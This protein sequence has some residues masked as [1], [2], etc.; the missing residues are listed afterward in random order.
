M[1]FLPDA[2]AAPVCGG[3]ELWGDCSGACR[4]PRAI[5]VCAAPAS[6]PAEFLAPF[7]MFFKAGSYLGNAVGCAIGVTLLL[8]SGVVPGL[9]QGITATSLAKIS[10]PVK[11]VQLAAAG[12][13]RQ[14]W[15]LR[16]GAV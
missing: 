3:W 12:T 6:A 14:G 7:P 8:N 16:D 13:A 9:M 4:R 2:A 5:G 10:Y 11:Q 1:K 15:E